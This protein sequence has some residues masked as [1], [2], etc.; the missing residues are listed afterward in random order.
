MKDAIQVLHDKAESL[1]GAR[2]FKMARYLTSGATAAA[3]NIGIL[4]L[5]VQFGQMHYLPASVIAFVCSVAVSFT[6]QK[7]WTFQDHHTHD[8]HSQFGRYLA[9]ILTNLALNTIFVYTLV[10]KFAV[11]YLLAQP[12]SGLLLAVAGYYAYKHLVFQARP[13]ATKSFF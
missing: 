3:T 5:L 12:I 2:L 10:E 11:W 4:F 6:L 7:F 8:V 1:L 9:V 13:T